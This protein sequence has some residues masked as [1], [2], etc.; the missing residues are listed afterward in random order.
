MEPEATPGVL[1][2]HPSE[3]MPN[4]TPAFEIQ[5]RRFSADCWEHYGRFADAG[6]ALRT[7]SVLA[8]ETA[9]AWRII[10]NRTGKVIDPRAAV[11]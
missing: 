9:A 10:D 3:R 1:R 4:F 11:T 2:R 8:E 6:A 7:L 5:T